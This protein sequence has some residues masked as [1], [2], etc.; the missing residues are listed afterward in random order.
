MGACCG[1]LTGR[2][3]GCADIPSLAM[4]ANTRGATQEEV[5][6]IPVLGKDC[7]M[8]CATVE[9]LCAALRAKPRRQACVYVTRE[10]H[11][12][13][14]ADLSP[15]NEFLQP[16]HRLRLCAAGCN[17]PPEISFW[18]EHVIYDD[19]YDTPVEFGDP[20]IDWVDSDCEDIRDVSKLE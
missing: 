15:L 9:A 16:H 10:L 4:R 13:L 17:A 2:R 3:E 19:G 8:I 11:A 12:C 6:N 18:V 20:S 14:E 1:K 5:P 7:S